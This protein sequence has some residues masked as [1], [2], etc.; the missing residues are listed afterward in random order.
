MIVHECVPG[1]DVNVIDAGLNSQGL[2]YH[3]QSL[4]FSPEEE[5][6]THQTTKA[7]HFVLAV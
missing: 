1:F 3:V 6:C 5:W 7:I 2:C 4:V